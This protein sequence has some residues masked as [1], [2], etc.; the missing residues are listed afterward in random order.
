[1][2]RNVAHKKVEESDVGATTCSLYRFNL[3]A[4]LSPVVRGP[5]QDGVRPV[6]LFGAEQTS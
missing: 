2:Q 5:A 3:A 1:M 6:D 4:D